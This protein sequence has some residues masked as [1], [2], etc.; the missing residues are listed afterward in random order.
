MTPVSPRVC[1]SGLA[2]TLAALV[3][4]GLF[5]VPAAHANPLPWQVS[6]W[7]VHPWQQEFC[8]VNPITECSQAAQYTTATGIMEF[9]LYV[10][11]WMD[12]FV[13]S[14]VELDVSWPATWSFIL[15]DCCSPE[16]DWVEMPGTNSMQ[17][18]LS[19][20]N[21][22]S[23]PPGPYLVGRLKMN[24]PGYGGL[25]SQILFNGDWAASTPAQAGV[26]ECYQTFSC[27]TWMRACGAGLTPQVLEV[28]APSGQTASGTIHANLGT[29]DF[30]YVCW[31]D[32]VGDVPW[33]STSVHYLDPYTAE[34]SIVAD[35][36][37]LAP[38]VYEENL[39]TAGP[40]HNCALVRF[41]VTE[42]V[43]SV[44]EGPPIV[45]SVSWGQLKGE[46][47]KE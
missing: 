42:P 4:L 17:I 20:L 38:G 37:G 25:G 40:T 21:P 33:L 8:T 30:G 9:D 11:T 1:P 19:Y 39:Y 36:A 41:T 27:R 13:L 18:Q 12:P 46:R 16:G 31:F 32:L 10:W 2:A 24:C 45:R 28:T 6:V 14:T 47:V 23:C 34:V 44:P 3:A 5:S 7:N 29:D 26:G 15:F 43:T 22:V 35:A